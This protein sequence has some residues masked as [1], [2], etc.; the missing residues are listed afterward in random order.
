MLA[1][2]FI[3]TGIVINQTFII[4]S[5]DWGKFAMAQS[6]MIYSILTVATLFFSGFLVDKF[7]SRKVFPLLNVPLLFSLIVLATF[8]HPYTAFVFMGLMGISNGLTNVLMVSF[9]AEIYGVNYLGSIKALTGSLMVFSTALATAVFGILIDLG[10]SIEN[11]A[12]F[13]SIYTAI[14]IIIVL[15]FQKNYKP[16]FQNK[17]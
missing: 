7:T 11:I 12:V 4:E 9:W 8:D 14:S 1:S 16:V 3:I 5:K 13:C 2:S 10:Y 6:F 17:T 15:I